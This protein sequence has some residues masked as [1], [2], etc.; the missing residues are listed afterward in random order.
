MRIMFLGTSS[1][2]GKTT[3]AAMMCRYAAAE[4][5]SVSPFKASNLSSSWYMTGSGAPVG[6][7]QAFQAFASG[8][9]PDADMGPFILKP[10][11]GKVIRYLR[12][13]P[14]DLSVEE[15]VSEALSSFDSLSGRYDLVVCEG[16]GS[17]AELNLKGSD[18]A[19]MRMVRE[20]DIPAVIVGD[21]E[22]GGVFAAIYGTWKLMPEEER[23][24]LRGFIINRFRGDISVLNPGIEELESMTGMRCFGVI[25]YAD[26]RVP[27]EDTSESGA[28]CQEG[29]RSLDDLMSVCRDSV[30]FGAMLRISGA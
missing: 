24:H 9:A 1:N 10:E 19:N 14:C 16:S 22:R 21:I 2:S 5:I 8:I 23:R 13:R 7:G 29:L 20:R 15:S 18:I 27:E 4:N 25:P 3:V 26:L 12:G 11:N 28:S 6:V 30:D 17:P